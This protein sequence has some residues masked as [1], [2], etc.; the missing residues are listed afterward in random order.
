[1]SFMGQADVVRC[2]GCQ[3][4]MTRSLIKL[5]MESVHRHAYVCHNCSQSSAICGEPKTTVTNYVQNAGSIHPKP[6][7]PGCELPVEDVPHE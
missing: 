5:P 7:T 2:P 6:Y 1:M 3:L 4:E